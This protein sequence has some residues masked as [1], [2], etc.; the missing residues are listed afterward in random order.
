[1]TVKDDGTAALVYCE[2][3]SKVY[4]KDLKT[5]KADVTPVTKNSYVIYAS[6]LRKDKSG[7][8]VTERMQSQRGSSKCQS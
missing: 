3:Q 7:V 8:W 1:M 6:V 4:N 5:G 2:D